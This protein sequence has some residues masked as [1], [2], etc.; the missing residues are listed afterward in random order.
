MNNSYSGVVAPRMKRGGARCNMTGPALLFFVVACHFS[1]AA[2]SR[3]VFTSGPYTIL[4]DRTQTPT[5]RVVTRDNRT[6]WY[7]SA[8]NATFA[9]AARV[10]QAAEQN[11]GNFVFKTAVQE[12]CVDMQ[13]TGSGS[14]HSPHSSEYPQVESRLFPGHL[15]H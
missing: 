11:G 7:T 14:R 15:D 3:S 4:Y 1:V 2:S 5:L 13:I 8:S 6:V 10:E 12:V 9:T